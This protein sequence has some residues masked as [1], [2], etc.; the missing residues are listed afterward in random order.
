[1][2]SADGGYAKPT[3]GQV[4]GD[5][6]VTLVRPA[7]PED[8]GLVRVDV[9]KERASEGFIVNLPPA[10]VEQFVGRAAPTVTTQDGAQLPDW[11]SFDPKN[12]VFRASAVPSGGLPMMVR[13]QKGSV[14]IFVMLRLSQVAA[15][16]PKQ[17][18]KP[19]DTGESASGLVSFAKTEV[20]LH[21]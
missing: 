11:L 1:V 2:T 19:V 8:V 16:S 7:T 14:S 13:I 9:P 20:A 4:H 15:P 18:A 10:V 5:V 3:G 6:Q 21:Q 12:M 17:A